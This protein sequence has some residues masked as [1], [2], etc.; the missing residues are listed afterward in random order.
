LFPS[1]AGPAAERAVPAGNNPD[2]YSVYALATQ[3]IGGVTKGKIIVLNG[4]SS[5]GKS[6]LARKLQEIMPEPWFHLSLD[7]FDSMIH[8]RQPNSSCRASC[9]SSADCTPPP[10]R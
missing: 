8:S 3:R 6:S 5:A 7:T 1:P 2:A 10:G 4:V 9:G